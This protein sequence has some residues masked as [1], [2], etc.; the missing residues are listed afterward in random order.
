M[1]KLPQFQR[2]QEATTNQLVV[3]TISPGGLFAN[4]LYTS[5]NQSDSADAQLRQR[6]MLLSPMQSVGESTV[7]TAL[8]SQLSMDGFSIGS[9]DG[10]N[11]PSFS[12]PQS[13]YS[14][15]S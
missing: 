7:A 13:I 14:S 12:L 6:M 11:A 1:F 9:R 4:K 3:G 10:Q 2:A 8:E 5:E 15:S